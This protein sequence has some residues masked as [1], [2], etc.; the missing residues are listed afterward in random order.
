MR[1]PQFGIFAQG[2]VAHEFIEFDLRPGV[3][4]AHAG[5]LI[6]QLQQP[7]VAAGGVNLVIAFGAD[8]WR[9]L[10]PDEAPASLGAFREILGLDGR[11]APS[12]QHDVF[13]WISGSSSDVVFE[14]S[15]AAV[16]AIAD[17]AA[18]AT[19]QACFVHRDSRD[20]TGFIDG[21]E[22]PPL[23]EAPLAA[24]VPPGEP[25]AGGSHVLA[26]RWVHDLARFEA[27]TQ[28]EQEQVFG[29]TKPDSVE[30]DEARKPANA[31]IARVEIEDERGDELE[32]YRRGVPYG[33]IAEHG[34]YFVAF[35]A[36][37]ERFE[38]MLARIFGLADGLR[39]R[40]TDFSRPVTG[41]FYFAPPL[42][43]LGLKE[44]PLHESE[45]ILR[46]IPLFD[47]CSAQQLRFI[48][49]RVRAREYPTGATLCTQGQS[50]DQFFV[51]LNGSADVRRDGSIL[52][53][54][55]P[56]DFFGEIA[57]I[58]EGARTATVVSSS[59][60]RCL[61]IDSQQFRSILGQNADIS[62]HILDAVTQRLRA[63]L[64]HDTEP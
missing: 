9:L 30:L 55:G 35:A 1:L 17:V 2:T 5:R 54:M 40:L 45:E 10:A 13:V 21:T 7:Q 47:R 18:V 28:A 34:I 51:I 59:P 15:R 4:K 43:L 24:L 22:N 14:H 32:I 33:T 29:R 20:L 50:A 39:D 64:P 61:V 49:S 26:M 31:H 23:L 60:M 6:T 56:G 58:D 16:T 48:A 53:T 27:L 44:T 46:K 25:G 37:R 36:D 41:A 11:R 62:V 8:L 19:E 12:T 3:D 52:R 38:R 57:L 63:L 42:T